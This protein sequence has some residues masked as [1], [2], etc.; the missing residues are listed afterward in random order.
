MND[1]ESLGMIYHAT[2][3]S[4]YLKKGIHLRWGF[5]QRLGFPRNGFKLYR[6]ISNFNASVSRI[7]FQKY[8]ITEA[9]YP[10]PLE[11][12]F[13]AD[14]ARYYSVFNSSPSKLRFIKYTYKNITKDVLLLEQDQ[15]VEISLPIQV[16]AIEVDVFFNDNWNG[17]FEAYSGD[18]LLYSAE[19][20]SLKPE[21]IYIPVL[22]ANKIVIKGIHQ[23]RISEIRF[24]TVH[25]LA[26][27]W[28]GPINAPGGYG[29][30]INTQISALK[31]LFYLNPGLLYP[32]NSLDNEVAKYGEDWVLAAMRLE[33]RFWRKH[34]GSRYRNFRETLYKMVNNWKYP[35]SWNKGIYEDTAVSNAGGPDEKAPDIHFS[36]YEMVLMTL[37]KPEFACILNMYWIDE[38]V[39]Q[40]VYYDYRIDGDW[41][42]E[43][44][45]NLGNTVDFNELDVGDRKGKVFQHKG[46]VFEMPENPTVYAVRGYSGIGISRILSCN[47]GVNGIKITMKGIQKEFQALLRSKNDIRVELLLAGSVVATKY[48]SSGEI[49]VSVGSYSGFDQVKIVGYIKPADPYTRGIP[50]N[51]AI[52]ILRI[53]TDEKY[54]EGTN[55]SY[56]LRGVRMKTPVPLGAPEGVAANQGKSYVK[57]DNNNVLIREYQI[58]IDWLLANESYSSDIN[59]QIAS[60]RIGRMLNGL[61]NSNFRM[62]SPLLVSRGGARKHGDGSGLFRDTVYNIGKYGYCI[63]GVD[64]WGRYGRWSKPAEVE[65]EPSRPSTP[66]LLNASIVNADDTRFGKWQR[67][68][69]KAKGGPV[70]FVNW[71]WTPELQKVNEDVSMFHIYFQPGWLNHFSGKMKRDS[72]PSGSTVRLITDIPSTGIPEN[73]F[74]GSD[75]TVEGCSY[76]IT[77]SMNGAGFQDIDITVKC[78]KNNDNAGFSTGTYQISEV[79][80]LTASYTFNVQGDAV[81]ERMVGDRVYINS[82]YFTIFRVVQ[83]SAQNTKNVEVKKNVFF[84]NQCFNISLIENSAVYFDF[85]EPSNW[86][87][88][89]TSQTVISGKV[90]YEAIIF[91]TPI[92]PDINHLI[93]YGQIGVTSKTDDGRESDVSLPASIVD[94]YRQAPPIVPLVDM[95]GQFSS[96][97]DFNGKSSYPLRFPKNNNITYEVFRA[98]DEMLFLVDKN[99][100]QYYFEKN[101]ARVANVDDFVSKLG[102]TAYKSEIV[103]TIIIPS[104]VD[105]T[106][107]KNHSHKN[108][109]L[110]ALANLPG[111][112]EAFV[113]INSF[114]VKPEDNNHK[115]R[116]CYFEPESTV[117][118]PC[119]LL[120]LDDTLKGNTNNVY[121]YRIRTKSGTMVT[122]EYSIATYPIYVRKTHIDA[123]PVMESMSASD[124]SICLSWS[125]V[126][127]DGL[128]GYEVYRTDDPES[129]SDIRQMDKLMQLTGA[130]LT[131][132]PG[133]EDSS[134]IPYKSY[135][136]RVVAF[137]EVDENGA[138]RTIKSHPSEAVCCK[139]YKA[140]PLVA[141]WRSARWQETAGQKQISLSWDHP[142]AGSVSFLLE[143]KSA[144]DLFWKQ[145]GDWTNVTQLTDT[146]TVLA[147]VSYRIKVK[148]QYGQQCSELAGID[149]IYQEGEI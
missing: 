100:R 18:K 20:G 30:P 105:Y 16:Q 130:I 95:P 77:K 93:L 22:D 97:P 138:K 33:K 62:D 145:L 82:E 53:C 101:I 75:I 122:S 27:K 149:C 90:Q 112:E 91:P 133:M 142:Q 38:N 124:G 44:R 102:L 81:N 71:E 89:I 51:I 19:E 34:R 109:L 29:L 26:D 147:D 63:S 41:G 31:D 36:Y 4:E 83:N 35:L 128:K 120:Y 57:K 7:T 134:V 6:R 98:M 15:T 126:T 74:T 114:D 108:A 103:N 110:K 92:V 146:P 94:V 140:P 107:L 8:T 118:D 64:V 28:E 10:V 14:D 68:I 79:K 123:T 17:I 3:G 69:A 40:G 88:C 43:E 127:A 144:A 131:D 50:N 104:T 48:Y 78:P 125:R 80:E 37:L 21:T 60:Y 87:S 116:K 5:N 84:T 58:N 25:E 24:F 129:A 115:N 56:L 76:R 136:Y 73:A 111:N 46:M 59:E 52:D 132:P 12:K 39:Q 2:N 23:L 11:I 85:S 49:L 141:V 61:Q 96:Y 67:D 121:F 137:A 42:D 45:W 13:A 70:L 135:Y 143:K 9:Y 148:D 54:I 119:M 47:T 55:K 32:G 86:E 113:R 139:T 66:N 106:A 65:V 117:I 99:C 1:F 72:T